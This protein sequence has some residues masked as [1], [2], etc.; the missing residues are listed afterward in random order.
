MSNITHRYDITETADLQ[1]TNFLFFSE[2][3]SGKEDVLKIV[4]FAYVR[5]FSN[6]PIFNLGFGDFDMDTGE[7]N[8]ES[9]TDNGDVYKIFNTVL[10]TIPLFFSRNPQAAILVRGSDGR[11]E[12]EYKCKQNC[13]RRCTASCHN[14]NRRM[15]LY[16][17]YVSRKHSI[18][19]ADYQ[20]LGGIVNS[21]HW[22]DLTEFNPGTLYDGII[23][24]K[25]MC[26]F[27]L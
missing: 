12:F 2:G 1:S 23:V 7:I 6:K 8:D 3:K 27:E 24:S 22:L 13:P 17:N 18:F 26:K 5:D 20:F 4:Q 19:Q 25:K 11:A 15:K 10:S 14:F 21:E 16:C 9:M